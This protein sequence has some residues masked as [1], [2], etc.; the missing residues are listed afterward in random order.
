[1]RGKVSIIKV[2]LI[3]VCVFVFLILPEIYLPWLCEWKWKAFHY[4]M[5]SFFFHLSI[6]ILNKFCISNILSKKPFEFRCFSVLLTAPKLFLNVPYMYAILF[7]PYHPFN[8]H[9]LTNSK[10]QLSMNQRSFSYSVYIYAFF[11]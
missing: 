7:C 2:I 11:G 1:M 6:S 8:V 4:Q 10:L 5:S 9:N 3:V